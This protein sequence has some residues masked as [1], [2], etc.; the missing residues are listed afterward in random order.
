[1]LKISQINL[2]NFRVFKDLSFPIKPIT[3]LTGPNS[4][5]KSSIVKALLLLQDNLDEYQLGQLDFT[6]DV[7]RL[8][9]FD[10]VLTRNL[11]TN[12]PMCF[13]LLYQI[14][15]LTQKKTQIG[16][17]KNLL[18]DFHS[19]T[20]KVTYTYER[21]KDNPKSGLL[22]SL[23]VS[24]ESET[25]ILSLRHSTNRKF[26]ITIDLSQIVRNI[27]NRNALALTPRMNLVRD[28]ISPDIFEAHFAILRQQYQ[29][30]LN[31][32]L[33]KADEE[34]AH[35]NE[36]NHIQE[37]KNRLIS[38]R[39]TIEETMA[40]LQAE[41]EQKMSDLKLQY[42]SDN[43]PQKEQQEYQREAEILR[44]Q[45]VNNNLHQTLR[46]LETE[47]KEAQQTAIDN[48]HHKKEELQN[49]YK[50][51]LAALIPGTY[52][53]IIYNA[54]T[55][56][57]RTIIQ[58]LKHKKLTISI[59]DKKAKYSDL[60]SLLGN[61][62]W[63][64][65]VANKLSYI[66]DMTV[67]NIIK[68]KPELKFL[69]NVDT[70]TSIKFGELLADGDTNQI[71]SSII[72][73]LRELVD[74][75]NFIP[76]Q[77]NKLPF[78]YIGAI[79]GQQKRFY[80]L[81]DEYPLDHSIGLLLELQNKQQQ[82]KIAFINYWLEEFGIIEK[83]GSIMAEQI[84]G[85]YT[86]IKL[87]RTYTERKKKHSTS[88]AD[89]GMG[90]SQLLPIIITTAYYLD[91]NYLIAIEEP[92]SHLHPKLQSALADF[93]VAAIEKGVR[94]LVETHSVY[95]IR[96]LEVLL[97]NKSL[98]TNKLR[99]CYVNKNPNEAIQDREVVDIKV[100]EDGLDQEKVK[101]LWA[102]F[103]DEDERLQMEKQEIKKFKTKLGINIKCL[104]LTEDKR[105]DKDPYLMTLL[106]ASGF[107]A[108]ETQIISYESCDKLAT[109]G[110]GMA[111][112]VQT[113]SHIEKIIFHI[114]A[115]G[116]H[117]KRKENLMGMLKSNNISKGVPFITH[118]NSIEG[119]FVNIAHI[120]ELF[121]GLSEEKLTEKIEFELK[122]LEKS[123]I[124]RLKQKYNSEKAAKLLYA[125]D[126]LI[127]CDAKKLIA[128][129]NT[130]LQKYV[131]EKIIPHNPTLL[132]VSS[133]LLDDILTQIA[134]EIWKK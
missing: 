84:D 27:V 59:P 108:A 52:H 118:Y 109:I 19:K 122:Q 124:E 116:L 26:Y 45:Q 121:S 5:G 85:A 134:A 89:L 33:K 55:Q 112:Y 1:M 10:S 107:V 77:K 53:S 113:L 94:F 41:Y 58:V 129:V 23:S 114:D 13:E 72:A 2:K 62:E 24:F 103:Y 51:N 7:H 39:Q 34:I 104:V 50:R 115:D 9:G 40:K 6:N 96:K 32:D 87:Y 67:G 14:E 120:L 56:Y 110:M 69:N 8:G 21:Q 54:V 117:E 127:Y 78:W 81:N 119:Y 60:M 105:H 75:F 29:R 79:R 71:L 18:T 37:L 88:I 3:I 44:F 65:F 83:N 97:G 22:I 90:I 99:V 15:V 73:E 30:K 25:S 42:L 102:G 49:E 57:G 47:I 4:S 98:A 11:P 70:L 48:I 61:P 64:S 133:V 86:N 74:T 46:N 95:L 31:A 126:P 80:H 12:S 38:E 35:I 92:E 101:E 66:G 17:K 91:Q 36:L 128:K 123:D 20:L 82:D 93:M 130:L 100:N 132:Q 131:K 16:T 28:N 63:E 43:D 111:K 106:K 68:G 76:K 125:T